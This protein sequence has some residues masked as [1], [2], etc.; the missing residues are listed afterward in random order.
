M[1]QQPPVSPTPR[2]AGIRH[3]LG[4]CTTPESKASCSS[5]PGQ[6]LRSV[7]HGWG[8]GGSFPAPACS[9]PA[10]EPVPGVRPGPTRAEGG[11]G[12]GG[13][14]IPVL[15][16]SHRLNC[17]EKDAKSCRRQ[18]AGKHRI[19]D[20]RNHEGWKRSLRTS[21]PAITPSPP[22]LLN[23]VPKCHVYTFFGHPYAY[24]LQHRCRT[25]NQKMRKEGG[26]RLPHRTQLTNQPSQHAAIFQRGSCWA[27][28][29]CPRVDARTR[30][31][32]TP[33]SPPGSGG[34]FAITPRL[35]V[36]NMGV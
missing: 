26:L 30:F 10:P 13:L 19:I 33:S 31:Q 21:G 20:S 24:L 9:P 14:A 28:R 25:P 27:H 4:P 32:T 7:A 15:L 1:S 22:C 3:A 29:R 36:I 16:P 5:P 8:S 11:R 6:L 12:E 23:H 17:H 34:G 2:S 18:P 35:N